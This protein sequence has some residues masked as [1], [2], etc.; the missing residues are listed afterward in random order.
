MCPRVAH[1]SHQGD[2]SLTYLQP[3]P[4]QRGGAREVESRSGGCSSRTSGPA[5]SSP[6]LPRAH[7]VPWCALSPTTDYATP[8]IH[9]HTMPCHAMSTQPRQSTCGSSAL[10]N[11]VLRLNEAQRRAQTAA[12]PN[13]VSELHATSSQH[14][15]QAYQ[16]LCARV[17]V[18]DLRAVHIFKNRICQ[19]DVLEPFAKETAPLMAPS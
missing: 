14:P 2:I 7:V 11:H 12:R 3:P 9:S 17:C 15:G 19:A 18:N 13:T 1:R 4:M 8:T 16:G 5:P 6:R 10:S